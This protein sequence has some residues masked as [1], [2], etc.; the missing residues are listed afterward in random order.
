VPDP[1]EERLKDLTGELHNDGHHRVAT[2]VV[3]EHLGVRGADRRSGSARRL[4]RAMRQLGW[5]PARF[6]LTPGSYQR[7]RGF[8]RVVVQP[9]AWP[10]TRQRLMRPVCQ[11]LK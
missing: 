6:P 3:F 2:F 4:A 10:A 8:Q 11:T 1:W 9:D 7:V 5:E